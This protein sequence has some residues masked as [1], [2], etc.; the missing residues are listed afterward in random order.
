M[1][2]LLSYIEAFFVLPKGAPPAILR[3]SYSAGSR[4]GCIKYYCGLP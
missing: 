1:L 3:L 2:L 4:R